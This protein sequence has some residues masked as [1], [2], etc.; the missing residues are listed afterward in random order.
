MK[1]LLNF[2]LLFVLV[3]CSATAKQ[4]QII[5]LS[6]NDMHGSI[7]NFAKVAAFVQKERAKNPNVIVL[8]GGDM[9]S[10][11][12][13]VDQHHEKG[14]PII[15]LMNRIG[16]QY[17]IFGNHEFDYG[18]QILNDRISQAKFEFLCANMNVD[19]Q[20]ASIKQPRPYATFSIDGVKV[21]LLALTGASKRPDGR[22]LPA[23]HPDRL[24][25]LE[26]IDPIGTALKHKEL[27]N[28]CDLFLALTHI[29]YEYDQEL[30][31][32]M[33][34][35]DVIIGGHSHTRIDSTLLINNVLVTQTGDHL[36]FIGKTTITLED[37]KVM[38]KKFELINVA[39]LRDE[40][41][42][43]KQ[44]IQKFHDESPLNQVLAQASAQ[45]DGKEPLGALMTDAV[46]S[47]HKLD[48]AF[49]N[50]GGI[51]IPMIPKGKITASMVYELD[52]FGN[53][54]VIYE[55]TPAEIRLLIKNSYRKASK[56][57]DLMV[58]GMTY[59]IKT[60]DDLATD[61]IIKDMKGRAL[62]E[63]KLYKVGM[64]SYISSSYRFG[65]TNPGTELESTAS[66]ALIE[67]LKK[68][69]VVAPQKYRTSVVEE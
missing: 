19:P 63:N 59:I 47:V 42:E 4:A 50:A 34:E 52:P 2:L 65:H 41:P 51:R 68:K 1:R 45:F 24:T 60:H 13:I 33:P 5:I 48:F 67:Y 7:D 14:F 15:D 66:D 38:D 30:A 57:A 11:N 17:E 29:G 44:L 35:L 46:T 8:S 27:R 6:T 21:C 10:G 62:D 37:N 56:R 58:S 28:D 40:D 25:G 23:A 69:K 61:V 36:N 55:M 18:Q 39:K 31:K 54:V 49:Q 12:P 32:A 53:R 43:I 64:N 26:F 16:Y 3:F 22:Y 20:V 9:F